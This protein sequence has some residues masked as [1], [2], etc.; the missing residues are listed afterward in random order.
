MDEQRLTHKKCE[1]QYHIV[2]VPKYRRKAIYGKL[3]QDIGMI[4]RKLCEYKY[5]EIIE[6]YLIHSNY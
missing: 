5:V 6:A 1:C 3:R 2:T 4:L